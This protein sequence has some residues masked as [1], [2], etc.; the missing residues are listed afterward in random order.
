MGPHPE[1]GIISFSLTLGQLSFL[2]K[3]NASFPI[4]D[5]EAFL[6]AYEDGSNSLPP[7]LLCQVYAQSLIYWCHSPVLAPHP[8]P[9][10]R[11]AV[12]LAVAAL[13]EEF[14][15]P[16]L[17]TLGSALID[18]TGRPIFS[19]TGNAINS[20][21]TVALSHC[22]GL[23]RDP[24]SWKLSREEKNQRIR[25]WWGVTIHDRW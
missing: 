13:H 21:R 25:L 11:Y 7:P 6:K 17:S 18:L 1:S 12:N 8:K 23:N 2:D 19:M 24:S 10:A 4:F 3:I 14:S 22:L 9:D 16:G 20:G 15:A 5:E